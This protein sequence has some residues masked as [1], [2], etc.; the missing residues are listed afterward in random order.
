[1]ATSYP[2]SASRP[3]STSPAGPAPIAITSNVVPFID[4]F[5]SARS[6]YFCDIGDRGSGGLTPGTEESRPLVRPAGRVGTN[7]V[8][9]RRHW[10]GPPQTTTTE[11]EGRHELP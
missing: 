10:C 4:V 7:H 1:M 2:L 11:G 9:P 6:E 5:S 8:R 3:A